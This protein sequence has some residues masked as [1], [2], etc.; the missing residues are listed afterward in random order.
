MPRTLEDE[1]NLISEAVVSALHCLMDICNGSE[2]PVEMKFEAASRIL[3]HAVINDESH[4]FDS[5][6]DDHP[7][8]QEE[9]EETDVDRPPRE[10]EAR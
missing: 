7:E 4:Q 8:D 2:T 1:Q 9:G 6:P 5:E 3:T 10:G